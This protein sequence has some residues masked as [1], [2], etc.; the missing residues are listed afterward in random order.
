M[1]ADVSRA[2][3]AKSETCHPKKL[4]AYQ[5]FELFSPLLKTKMPTEKAKNRPC[6]FMSK[7]LG[8]LVALGLV[9]YF[10]SKVIIAVE[11]LQHEKTAV[12]MT[13]HYEESR[14]MPSFSIGFRNRKKHYQYNGTEVELGL[15]IT[16]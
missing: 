10:V 14:L 9:A 15:N 6:V 12:S 3:L 7:A 5:N 1:C 11:K 8:R 2:V 13:T 16:K 4:H